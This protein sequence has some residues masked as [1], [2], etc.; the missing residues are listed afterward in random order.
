MPRPQ[1]PTQEVIG[2]QSSLRSL[3]SSIED[4]SGNA[5]QVSVVR[6]VSLARHAVLY[7]LAAL[8][9]KWSGTSVDAGLTQGAVNLLASALDETSAITGTFGLLTKTLVRDEQGL[10]YELQGLRD[11]WPDGLSVSSLIGIN[12][13]FLPSADDQVLTYDITSSLWGVYSD[14]R[15]N[16]DESITNALSLALQ[17]GHTFNASGMTFFGE[18]TLSSAFGSLNIT[19][20]SSGDVTINPTGDFILPD[21]LSGLLQTDVTGIVSSFAG[22]TDDSLVVWDTT[23]SQWSENPNILAV[24]NVLAGATSLGLAS[25]NGSI[26]ISAFGGGITLATS[27]SQN[28]TINPGASGSLVFSDLLSGL[29]QTNGSGVA[30]KLSGTTDGALCV[31][32][33]GTSLWEENTNVTAVSGVVSATS[34]SLSSVLSITTS[35][36]T[37]LSGDFSILT[38]AG[39][40]IILN[41]GVGGNIVCSDL[42]ATTS[43]QA[44]FVV[45][46]TSSELS[47]RTIQ[48]PK[49]I[50]LEDN[51]ASDEFPLAYVPQDA[52]VIAVVHKTDAGTVDYNIEKRS[53]LTP[54]SSGTNIWTVDEQAS[55]TGE[56]ITSFNSASISAGSWLTF[57]ASAVSSATKLWVAVVLE[58]AV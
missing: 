43:A 50:Y 47:T 49:L 8:N 23:T 31:Y 12:P 37:S 6:A 20:T 33:T 36:L 27:A 26:S 17:A 3:G 22:T 1:P 5:E 35:G 52:T 38:S 29:I 39:G 57:S 30:S 45:M 56:E 16:E 15:I 18:G 55:S 11:L 24:A 46:G 28:I 41:P 42:T 13:S 14:V 4:A 54:D 58:L 32:D 9:D 53:K 10:A 19:T 7:E 2:F 48:I 51:D 44:Q 25:S 34:I 21:L 40:D